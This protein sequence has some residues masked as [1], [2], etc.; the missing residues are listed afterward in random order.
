M[1]DRKLNQIQLKGLLLHRSLTLHRSR[2]LRDRHS[3]LLLSIWWCMASRI[4]V[5]TIINQVCQ[6]LA[7][8]VLHIKVFTLNLSA[9]LKYPVGQEVLLIACT[10]KSN[11]EAWHRM[12]RSDLVTMG[13]LH[14]CRF[15]LLLLHMVA[16]I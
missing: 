5:R 3:S 7:A 10:N 9:G 4:L 13:A 2:N 1:A 8:Q 11:L 15:H 16:T 6:C 12:R 14:R